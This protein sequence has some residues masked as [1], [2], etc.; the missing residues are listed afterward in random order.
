MP[1]GSF[2]SSNGDGGQAWSEGL[3]ENL[4]S[5]TRMILS[6]SETQL[7]SIDSHD[8]ADERPSHM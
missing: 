7:I 2:C 4:W 6:A 8:G 3:A 5:I 1:E